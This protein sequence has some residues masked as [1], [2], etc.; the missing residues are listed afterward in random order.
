YTTLFRSPV[1]F[2]GL[3]NE[4]IYGQSQTGWSKWGNATL[5]FLATT[6]A[7]FTEGTLGLVN[8]VYQAI[9]DGKFS[10]FY[11]NEFNRSLDRW[12][13]NLENTNPNYYTQQEQDAEW[14]SPNTWLTNN[15][16]ADTVLKNAGFAVGAFAS[17]GV[18][19]KGVGAVVNAIAKG[20]IL[21]AGGRLAQ[22]AQRVEQEVSTG[23]KP[24][25]FNTYKEATLDALSNNFVTT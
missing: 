9:N 6:G 15:F 1:Q 20:K 2:P 11:D 10:S 25:N 7:T 14:Y 5:K 16:W 13:E 8:G 3:N 12:K 4:D 21:G 24:N 22:S 18:W 23:L 19:T 17:G